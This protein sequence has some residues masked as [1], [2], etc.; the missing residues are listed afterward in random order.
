[1]EVVFFSIVGDIRIKSVKF[2]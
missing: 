1:M 2:D